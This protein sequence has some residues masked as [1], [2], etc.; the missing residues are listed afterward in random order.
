M[1]GSMRRTFYGIICFLSLFSYSWALDI[2]VDNDGGAPDYVETGSWITGGYPGYNGG[3]YRYATAGGAHTA[4]WTAA[5]GGGNAEIF[6]IYVA[7][8]NRASSARYVVH[9][10]DG[11][12]V[13]NVNQQINSL[14]W[15][16]LG[17]FPMVNGDNSITLDAAG[18]S[19]GA[20]VIADAV[21][22][23]TSAPTPTPTPTPTPL[24]GEWRAFWADAWHTGFFNAS[25]VTDMVNTAKNNN[26]NAI[27]IQVRRRGDAFYFPTSPNIEPRNS[28]IAGDFDPLQET[29]TQAHA[30]G[31]EV[32][33]WMTTFPIASSTP[34]SDP[35]H[36]YNLH[37]EY[38]MANDAGETNFPEGYYLDPGNPGSNKWNYNVVMDLVTHYNIDGIHF[39]YIRYPQQN[40]GY[41]PTAIARYNAEF[42]LSGKPAYTDA[43]FS[44]W[45]RRQVTDWLRATYVDIIAVK[46]DIRVTASVFASRSDAYG[47][48]FQDWAKWMQD[49]HMDALCPMNYTIENSIFNS[50]TDDIVANRYM[51]HVYMGNGAYME[52]MSKEQTVTQLLYARGKKCE[53]LMQYSYQ[54]PTD[55][56]IGDSNATVYAYIKANLFPS[57]TPIPV[58]P[59]K[60]EPTGGYLR[61]KVTDSDTANPIYNATITVV[62]AG[63]SIK[64]DG[65][66]K[67]AITYFQPGTYIVTCDAAGY[68]QA[69]ANDVVITAGGVTTVN[70][71]MRD[72][73]TP[74]PTPTA[75][76]TPT[77]VPPEITIL[78]PS[79]SEERA[80]GKYTISWTDSDPDDDASISLYFDTDNTGANGVLITS[81]ISEDSAI[82]YY[83]CNTAAA[84]EGIY[85]IYGVINDGVNPPVVS[86]S[87][88]SVMAS[89]ITKAELQN[90]LLNDGAIP[91]ERLAYADFN[92]DG[93]LDI[94]D[95]IVLINHE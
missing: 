2:I 84:P 55:P 19:G 63:K 25:E 62:G 44:T 4:R 48:R 72:T 77:N 8:G 67:Y 90:H 35:N 87:A 58:M 32:H 33:V 50:R 17:T 47:A 51:R 75:T 31:L 56:K 13:V 73:P 80:F 79:D 28:S 12:H 37:P 29:I 82:N 6:V 92:D 52:G 95:L 26:Y 46:P 11:D 89:R 36:V 53:G 22:F 49:N 16:S 57:A 91:S 70:F 88:G 68:T 7:G 83:E 64:S 1:D 10:S 94:A 43:Q 38:L 39:D 85:W 93:V 61:G 21:T 24:V 27:V 86:Y 59:W 71:S 34:S 23:I 76:A 45:R 14:T 42:G 69:Q 30:V 9:A 81:G 78:T 60:T 54:V 20:V 18:S 15:I 41:N 3:T 74:T 5:L 66:G 65:E 40:A